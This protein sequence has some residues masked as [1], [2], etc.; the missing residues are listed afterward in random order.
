[1]SLPGRRTD[2]PTPDVRANVD[3][4]TVEG[5]G[6]EWKRFDQSRASSE[7]LRELFRQYFK[8]FP[9]D[10]LPRDAVGFDAGCGSGRWAQFV[11]PRV[12]T[13]HCID[14]S[15]EALEVA[16]RNLNGFTNA[17]FHHASVAEMP[18]PD[19]S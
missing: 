8:L 10:E 14:A 7:E 11:L 18:I 15:G 5:F 12:G 19:A 2:L 4:A 1:M 16:K 13:L 9:W 17:R 3:A 6:D